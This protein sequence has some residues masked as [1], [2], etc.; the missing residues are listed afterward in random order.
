MT[1]HTISVVIPT[2]DRPEF[3][4]EAVESALAQTADILEVIV[5]DDASTLDLGPALARFGDKVR[6][7]RLSENS[8]ANVAR[9]R[10][11]ALARGTLIGFLDDDDMWV[12][13][14]AARQ[15]AAIESGAEACLCAT[16]AM[17][18]TSRE[19]RGK[20]VVD[21]DWLRASTPCGTSGLVALR[22]VMEAERFDPA[23]PR[24][25]DWDVFV[26]LAK[27]GPIAYIDEPL[28]IRRSGHDRITTA[29]L[30][31]TPAELFASAAALHKHR[32]WLGEAAY[33]RRLARVLLSFI[34]QRRGKFRYLA[35]ALRHA[36][37]RATLSELRRKFRR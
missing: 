19:K 25:Q 35:A 8:G 4:A 20:R 34:A 37:L 28:Y 10:G 21:E 9:N 2:H 17:D 13:H 23:I 7:E 24:G 14:K 29:A 32:R 6:Y 27:R 36:G 3:L 12:P 30:R 33:R 1:K 5:V 18:G 26:R 16:R 11:I 22:A 31:R 15:I